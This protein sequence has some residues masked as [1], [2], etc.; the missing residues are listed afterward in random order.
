M[1][2]CC[3]KQNKQEP[4]EFVGKPAK[5]DFV[6]LYK[7]DKDVEEKVVKLQTAF[8]RH[9]AARNVKA[10]RDA[11]QVNERAAK[12]AA[13]PTP[14]QSDNPSD[15]PI[16]REMEEKFGPFKRDEIEEDSAERVV[17]PQAILD[18]GAKYTG[19]WEVIQK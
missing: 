19:Q 11:K 12:P 13:S 9:L 16:V 5:P 10:M 3:V 8:R 4:A 7:D 14:G 15:N 17:R 6:E 1:G 2:E 18:N